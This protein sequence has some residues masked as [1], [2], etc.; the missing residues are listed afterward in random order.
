VLI[1]LASTAWANTYTIGAGETY[2]TPNELYLSNVVSNGDTILIQASTY[3]G[4]DA[5]AVWHADDLKVFG[6]NGRPHL[7]A[8]GQNIWGKGIWVFAGDNITVENIE[9]SG[10][11]V[12]DQNGAGIRLDGIGMTARYCYFH[13]NEDGI[14]TSNPEA[15]DILIEYCEFAN[16]GFGDG[17]S[18]NLYIG[19][20]NRLTF[21][22]NYSHNAIVGHNLKSR[23]KENI[24]LYNRIMD[25]EDGNSSRLI[26][27]SNGGTA[28]I[29]GNLLMQG[30]NAPNKNLIGYGLEGLT[31]L[32]SHELHV[33]NNTMINKRQ[34]SGTFLD[35]QSGTAV[36]RIQNNIFGGIGELINGSSTIEDHNL[37]AEDISTIGL[38]DEESYNYNLNSDSPAIDNGVIINNVVVLGYNLQPEWQYAHSTEKEERVLSNMDIDIGAYEHSIISDTDILLE[39]SGISIYPNPTPDDLTIELHS[40]SYFLNIYDINGS[41][42]YNDTITSMVKLD[43]SPYQDGLYFIEL[44]NSVNQKIWIRSVLK[45]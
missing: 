40:G 7:E 11:S 26:D 36:V 16:N 1:F 37:I 17:Q 20:I 10:A 34:A 9:F 13:D 27:L 44:I 23:A 14:L 28:I 33:V 32:G 29:M 38:M 19:R 31:P 3:T 25:E 42:V 39:D 2:T 8:D 43:L 41:V 35:V 30:P 21:Q 6:I 45:Y 12:P 24:I 5:L 4:T 18:H 15:G 22:Y